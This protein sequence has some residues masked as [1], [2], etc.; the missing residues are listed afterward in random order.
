MKYKFNT[1]EKIILIGLPVLY[2]FHP[3]QFFGISSINFS[4]GDGIIFMSILFIFIGVIG[5]YRVPK[6]ILLVLLFVLIAVLSIFIP[7]SNQYINVYGGLFE[8]IKLIGAVMWSLVIYNIIEK[9]P[10]Q[11]IWIFSIFSIGIATIFAII[12]IYSGLTGA[13][14]RPS[15]PFQNPNL[16][17]NY[18]MTNFFL[19]FI[20]ISILRK[21]TGS[22]HVILLFIVVWTILIIGTIYTGSRGSLAGFSAGLFFLVSLPILNKSRFNTE[23]LPYLGYIILISVSILFVIWTI[24]RMN[25]FV[26]DRIIST[27]QGTGRN[28]DTRIEQYFFGIIVFIDNPIFGVGY[29]QVESYVQAKYGLRITSIHN[30]YIVVAAGTGVFGLSCFFGFLIQTIRD[31]I[32]VYIYE[33]DIALFILCGLIAILVQILFTNG[34]NFRSLWIL[35]GMA[36]AVSQYHLSHQSH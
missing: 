9:N 34:E 7:Y 1:L 26:V 30:T 6:Y 17:G 13:T 16:Y 35:I 24:L 8:V 12:T 11:G 32:R 28:I 4:F 20:C 25:P 33:S 31:L 18:L 36:A 29:H 21:R 10:V 23:Y 3:N 5:S 27:F 19:S 14:L 2:P 22:S 15:G